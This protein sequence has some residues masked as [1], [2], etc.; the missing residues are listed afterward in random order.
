MSKLVKGIRNP[1]KV[2]EYLYRKA[3]RRYVNHR[4]EELIL[5]SDELKQRAIETWTFPENVGDLGPGMKKE[6]APLKEDGS[7]NFISGRASGRSY[8]FKEPFVCVLQDVT[9]SGRYAA[10]QTSDGKLVADTITYDPYNKAYKSNRINNAIENSLPTTTSFGFK[11]FRKRQSNATNSIELAAVL[12]R[13]RPNYYH[14][15]LEHVLKLRGVERFEAETGR[16]VP[17]IL[18]PNPPNYVEE[19]IELLGFGEN[20]VIEWDNNPIVVQQLVVPSFPEPTPKTLQWLRDTMKENVDIENEA[21]GWIYVSRQNTPRGRKVFN[22]SELET[23]FDEHGVK[24]VYCEE[25]SLEEQIQIFSSAEGIIGP[26]GAGLANM[27]YASNTS[28]IELFNGYVRMPYYVLAPLLGHEYTAYSGTPVH[29]NNKKER[30][31]DFVANPNV[32]G[33]LLKGLN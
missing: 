4:Y 22:Y 27:V 30:D 11:T 10:V 3:V 24:E 2:P 18:P 16:Q 13:P 23:V 32:V 9:I 14:W 28:V 17:L 31:L 21:G 6:L 12:H 8:L 29:E 5:D 25:L 19:S 20:P 1:H 7:A 26:H 33:E 15:M